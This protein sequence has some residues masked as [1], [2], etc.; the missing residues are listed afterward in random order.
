MTLPSETAPQHIQPSSV[1][2]PGSYTPGH[3]VF[4]AFPSSKAG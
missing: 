1:R 2:D 3:A 4:W